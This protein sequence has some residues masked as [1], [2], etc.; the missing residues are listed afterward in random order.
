MTARQRIETSG[1]NLN[2]VLL[3][4][5]IIGAIVTTVFFFAPLRTL[6]GDMERLQAHMQTVQQV[7][8][9]QTAA[10]QT[11]AEVTADTKT[12]RRDV[13]N[14]TSRI[15]DARRRLELLERRP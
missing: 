14:N 7:Q 9:V 15:E 5:S 8:A 6:P 4:V 1:L 10:L 2:S 12:M 3:I 13:D 11:L